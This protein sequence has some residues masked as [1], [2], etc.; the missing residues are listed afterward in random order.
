MLV[1]YKLILFLYRWAKTFWVFDL[2]YIWKY[3]HPAF[4]VFIICCQFERTWRRTRRRTVVYYNAPWN[5][6]G[7][8]KGSREQRGRIL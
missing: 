1:N 2:F 8:G 6:K 7:K 5:G 3:P 4:V